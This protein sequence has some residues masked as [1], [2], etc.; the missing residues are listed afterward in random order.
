MI[1]GERKTETLEEVN[2]TKGRTSAKEARTPKLNSRVEDRG[3]IVLCL[4]TNKKEAAKPLYL[5]RSE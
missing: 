1:C 3:E 2:Q 4:E 5:L